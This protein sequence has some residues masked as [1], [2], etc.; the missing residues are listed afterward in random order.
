MSI[1]IANPVHT[2]DTG[3]DGYEPTARAISE[4]ISALKKTVSGG[5]SSARG[6]PSA[7]PRKCA[8]ANGISKTSKSTPRKSALTKT[9]ITANGTKRKRTASSSSDEEELMEPENT[10]DERMALDTTPSA[11]RS[12]LS[13][14]SKS[15][16]KSYHDNESS[17]D[18][19]VASEEDGNTAAQIT[20]V[21]GSAAP[22]S[23][24]D[25]TLDMGFSFD[26]VQENGQEAGQDGVASA[27]GNLIPQGKTANG[28]KAN[29]T[30]KR[31]IKGEVRDDDSDGSDYVPIV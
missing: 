15:I 14:R 26:G 29:G 10:D 25:E 31:M 21:Q 13:R 16:A 6:T 28:I 30:A 7:T 27:N 8:T 23:S 11:P 3:I 24:A 19:A 4:H 20:A 22:G 18:D 12:T 1:K 5:T 2:V 9:P 17:E